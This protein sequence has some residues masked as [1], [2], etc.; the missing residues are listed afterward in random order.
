MEPVT[1][2]QT[3]DRTWSPDLEAVHADAMDCLD[4]N[5]ATLADH[6]HGAGTHLSLGADLAWRPREDGAGLPTVET[7]LDEHLSRAGDLLGLRVAARFPDLTAGS[8]AELAGM[9]DPLYVTG[10]AYAMPWLPYAGRRHMEHSFLLRR[11]RTDFLVLDAYHNDTPWGSHRPAVW[12]VP[13]PALAAM[14]AAGAAGLHLVP[15]DPP[16]L[17]AA[18]LR[19]AQPAAA[20]AAAGRIPE[21]VGRLR[22]HPDRVRVMARVTL[23]VWLLARARRLHAA[24]LAADPHVPPGVVDAARTHAT[25]W[26]GLASQSYVAQRRVERGSAEPPAVLQTLERL[27]RDDVVFAARLADGAPAGAAPAEGVPAPG[28]GAGGL[29]ARVRDAVVCALCEMFGTRPAMVT[30]EDNLRTVPGFSSFGLVGAIERAERQLGVELD[31]DDLTAD[32]LGDLATLCAIF[33]RAAR[34]A[35]TGTG[36]R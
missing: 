20:R 21:Y 15:G 9:A 33:E 28:P 24:W 2:T 1:V 17:D 5:L 23:D 6:H 34:S 29:S 25:A 18:A 30:A 31:P 26:A 3:Y 27:L 32:N 12:Q 36:T 35:P 14:L 13:A 11:G 8:L 4:V 19:A 16:A 22:D 7:T 10:D